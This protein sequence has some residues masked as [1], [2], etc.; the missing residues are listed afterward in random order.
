VAQGEMRP[1]KGYPRDRTLMDIGEQSKSKKSSSESF[2]YRSF[3]Y[4]TGDKSRKKELTFGLHDF[5]YLSDKDYFF[6]GYL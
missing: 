6:Y 5:A 4:R 1:E 2:R 3:T